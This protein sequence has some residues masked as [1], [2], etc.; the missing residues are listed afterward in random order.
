MRVLFDYNELWDIVESGVF[1]LAVN[2]NE[3]QRIVIRRRRRRII[4]LCISSIK[5]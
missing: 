3:A 1:A 5:G 4:R 2:A